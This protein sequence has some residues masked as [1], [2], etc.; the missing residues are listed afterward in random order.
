MLPS[1]GTPSAVASNERCI[2]RASR[3]PSPGD[4]D[5]AR[6]TNC[7]LGKAVLP[8]RE[9]HA[10]CLISECVC[11]RA[12]A[13]IAEAT[14]VVHKRSP[15]SYLGSWGDAGSRTTSEK[16]AEGDMPL[17]QDGSGGTRSGSA[18]YLDTAGADLPFSETRRLGPDHASR[19]ATGDDDTGAE[20]VRR[21]GAP[22]L[23]PSPRGCGRVHPPHREWS[24]AR[25]TSL[26]DRARTPSSA[27][28]SAR[29]G[30]GIVARHLSRPS[31]AR[32]SR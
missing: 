15:R 3:S 14:N 2:A 17:R 7:R 1:A 10:D 23:R 29:L 5:A 8:S 24:R 25:A 26:L 20:G 27:A 12:P 31:F 28:A 6:D 32:P 19:R 22:L 4:T 11:T 9:H 18:T 16:K 30:A 13:P 21:R